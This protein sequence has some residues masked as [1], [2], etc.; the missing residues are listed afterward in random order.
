MTKT[1]AL[2]R[3]IGRAE[4]AMRALLEGLLDEAG[5]SFSEW[6]ILV[7]LDGAGPLARDELVRRQVG[8]RVAPEAEARAAVD[9][10]LSRG[11]L[12]SDEGARGAGGSDGDGG[13]PRLAPTAVGEAAYRPVRRAVSRVT[14]ELFGGLPE[15]DLEATR[16]TLGEVARRADARL[17]AGG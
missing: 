14:G 9:G 8:G 1:P 11:L 7:F 15:A 12:T 16:R 6:T 10:L 5:L 17:T 4:R 13:G 2:T 3:D